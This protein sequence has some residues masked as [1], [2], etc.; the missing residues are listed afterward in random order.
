MEGKKSFVIYVSW[1]LWLD[2]LSD[3]QKG[4]WLNW[5]LDYTNDLNP[6]YPKD[7]AVEV[8]CRMAQ[9]TLKRDLKKYN[10]K[11]ERMQ[12]INEERN[13]NKVEETKNENDTKSLRNRDN[14]VGDNVN[15]NVNDNVN[16]ISK[17]IYNIESKDSCG[18]VS[19][20]KPTPLII[21][22][23]I[24]NYNHPI[25][26]EDVDHYKELYPAVDILQELKKM[27]GWLESNS[28][29][30]KTQNGI[31]S[32][33]T[34]WLSKCQDKAP[35]VESSNFSIKPDLGGFQEVGDEYLK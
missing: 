27:L 4:Q 28:K 26:Q 11:V 23:C 32:F 30:R 29:N 35:K 31:K 21:L 33:I 18:E 15:V 2:A 34:R 1:K 19:Q 12:R 25:F 22:P 8:A 20:D 13:K 6:E 5:M 9:D 7:K 17:D 16:V 24:N 10:A 14:I 3:E